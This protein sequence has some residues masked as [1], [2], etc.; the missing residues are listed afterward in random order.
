MLSKG[1]VISCQGC[2]VPSHSPYRWNIYH[3]VCAANKGDL[4]KFFL[5]KLPRD[6][7][8][9]LLAQKSRLREN[10][11]R[12]PHFLQSSDLSSIVAVAHCRQTRIREACLHPR[13]I[14]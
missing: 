12:S 6:V 2:H 10:T 3:L 4:L 7:N 14:Q 11:V 5:E 8:E 1:N 13:R 9:A